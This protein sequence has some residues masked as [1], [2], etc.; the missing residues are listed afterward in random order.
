VRAVSGREVGGWSSLSEAEGR[1]AA[2]EE[3]LESH[4]KTK[5]T[6]MERRVGLE[7]VSAAQRL[8]DMGARRAAH[9]VWG[10]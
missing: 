9:L 6:M 4:D 7:S 2:R 10:P 5:W 1:M 8:K 3:R